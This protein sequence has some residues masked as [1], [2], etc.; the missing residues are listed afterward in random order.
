LLAP[1]IRETGT[2]PPVLNDKEFHHQTLEF[3]NQILKSF[4]IFG[5]K[6][7]FCRLLHLYTISKNRQS[8]ISL[9]EVDLL[10]TVQWPTCL[11]LAIFV[12]LVSFV[13]VEPL[14]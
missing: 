13:A 11:Y 3:W 7:N 10:P 2:R 12:R 5:F 14:T 6:S 1:I 4:N 8:A 9:L